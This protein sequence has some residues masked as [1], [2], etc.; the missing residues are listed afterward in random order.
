M[1]STRLKILWIDDEIYTSNLIAFV[2]EFNDMGVDLTIDNRADFI[3][4]APDLSIY[5]GIIVDAMMAVGKYIKPADSNGGIYSGLRMVD[6][7]LRRKVDVSKIVIF[8]ILKDNFLR[9]KAEESKILYL[10]KHQNSHPRELAEKVI[11]H[12]KS[13]P[14]A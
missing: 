2:D 7:I 3:F 1:R 10:Y 11:N 13:N 12:I 4:E 14:K 9:K 6:E 8:S 5:D